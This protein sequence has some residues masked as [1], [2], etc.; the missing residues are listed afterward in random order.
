MASIQMLIDYIASTHDADQ[1]GWGETHIADT[2][3]EHFTSDPPVYDLFVRATQFEY[4]RETV[5]TVRRAVR[6]T[7]GVGYELI[8]ESCTWSAVP[9]EC[10]AE[11][12]LI[13]L[14]VAGAEQ[15][16]PKTIGDTLSQFPGA[17]ALCVMFMTT[18]P[19]QA[20]LWQAYLRLGMTSKPKPITRVLVAG[21]LLSAE[22]AGTNL[23]EELQ[24]SGDLIRFTVNLDDAAFPTWAVLTGSK[25][26]RCPR[27]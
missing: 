10:A 2:Y 26:F 5:S 19:L 15:C 6:Q 17:M 7:I 1:L 21:D 9:K 14:Q 4:H 25:I 23:E 24:R 27:W 22:F 18:I 8:E 12:A 20:R 13:A 16:L 11:P 3:R